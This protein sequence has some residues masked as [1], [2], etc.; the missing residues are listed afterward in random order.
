MN[1]VTA[2]FGDRVE[3]SSN[4]VSKLRSKAVVHHRNLVDKRVR[5]GK[6]ADAGTIAFGVIVAIDLIINSTAET[7]GVDLPG[8]AKFRVRAPCHIGL[9]QDEIVRI[10]GDERKVRHLLRAE[11]PAHIGSSRIYNGSA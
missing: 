7:V 5:E 6:K 1:L 8:N 9:E 2:G 10:A 3:D 11:R 4:R